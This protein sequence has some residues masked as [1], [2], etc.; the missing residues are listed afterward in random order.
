MVASEGVAGEMAYRRALQRGCLERALQRA[1]FRADL[2][3]GGTRLDPGFTVLS[4]L[5]KDL[6]L[7]QEGVHEEQLV[8]GGPELELQA[9][10][11]GDGDGQGRVG[12]GGVLRLPG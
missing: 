9:I 7:V 4:Q 1:A 10:L 8:E 6:R 3:G 2:F 11:V 5:V 12:H